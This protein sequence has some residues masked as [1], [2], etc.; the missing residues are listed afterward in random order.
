MSTIMYIQII[1][2]SILYNHI[3]NNSDIDYV[4]Y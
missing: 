2:Y 4:K 1:I 3:C